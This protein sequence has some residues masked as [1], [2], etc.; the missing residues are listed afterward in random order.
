[1]FNLFI[2]VGKV[3][4]PL[5]F[6]FCTM[7]GLFPYVLLRII[8]RRI[9]CLSLGPFSLYSISFVYFACFAQKLA[10]VLFW[11]A[12]FHLSSQLLNL[13]WHNL[14]AQETMCFQIPDNVGLFLKK[15]KNHD[16]WWA[17]P[18]GDAFRNKMRCDLRRT[19]STT[20]H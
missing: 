12:F 1:M 14:Q 13:C 9:R 16:P 17:E 10:E 11:E 20:S 3:I 6:C 7:T 8:Q 4:A 19:V 2:K 5:K 15:K 18:Q